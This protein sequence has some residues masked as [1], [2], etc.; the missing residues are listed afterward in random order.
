MQRMH[1]PSMRS[2][3]AQAQRVAA[4]HGARHVEPGVHR[5]AVDGVALAGELQRLDAHL[6][7]HAPALAG[8]Q[9]Q[10]LE[11]DQVGKRRHAAMLARRPG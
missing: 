10:G 2:V 4:G 1:A 8:A 11:I 9:V 3:E 7:V 5:A 6:G